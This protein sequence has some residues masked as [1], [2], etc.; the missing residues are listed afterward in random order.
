MIYSLTGS[1]CGEACW[2]ARE[3]ICRCSCGGKN[4]GCLKSG[5]GEHPERT[6]KIDGKRYKLA[7]VGATVHDDAQRLNKEAGIT[8]AY[9]H[10]ARQHWGYVPV[11][12]VR[13]A[14]KSQ[15]AWLEVKAESERVAAL[16]RWE[17]LGVNLL[18]VAA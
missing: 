8:Y 3:E 17:R 6:A 5:N 9:A 2:H 18:W 7:A 15:L 11:A 13:P 16:P 14:S 4:H 12:L 10:T 1:T